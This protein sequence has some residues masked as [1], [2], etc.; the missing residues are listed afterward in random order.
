VNQKPYKLIL[1]IWDKEQLP[2]QWNGENMCPI[3]KKGGR[4]KCKNYSP[5]TLLHT[6]Y[7]I[8]PILLNNRISDMVE[9]NRKNVKWDFV[10]IDLLMAIYSQLQ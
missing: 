4:L 3:Y 5:I 1:K 8:F 10:Q 6:A 2:T 7:K 9:K